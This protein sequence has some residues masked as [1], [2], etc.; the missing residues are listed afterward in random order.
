MTVCRWASRVACAVGAA[1]G[2]ALLITVASSFLPDAEPELDV[3]DRQLPVL[4][5]QTRQLQQPDQVF[6]PNLRKARHGDSWPSLRRLGKA[7]KVLRRWLSEAMAPESLDGGMLLFPAVKV[8]EEPAPNT[9]ANASVHMAPESLDG[10]MLLFPPVVLKEKAEEANQNGT[11]MPPWE[12]LGGGMVLFPPMHLDDNIA[13]GSESAGMVLFPPVPATGLAWN[14][15]TAAPTPSP[16]PVPTPAPTAVPTPAPPTPAPEDGNL[17]ILDFTTST[18]TI[19]STTTVTT[20]TTSTVTTLTTSTTSPVPKV[21]TELSGDATAGETSLTLLDVHGLSSGMPVT[22]ADVNNSETHNIVQVN[23]IVSSNGSRRLHAG[24]ITIDSPLQFSYDAGATITGLVQQ[25]LGG[26]W[27]SMDTNSDGTISSAEFTANSN[28]LPQTAS[29]GDIDTNGD[30]S[31]TY[32]EYMA[33]EHTTDTT[34]T[35]IIVA[36]ASSSEDDKDKN[37]NWWIP[38]VIIIVVLIVAWICFVCITKSILHL[39]EKRKADREEKVPFTDDQGL[40]KDEEVINIGGPPSHAAAHEVVPLGGDSK[41]EDAGDK[42]GTTS[43]QSEIF[44][45]GK[46]EDEAKAKGSEEAGA[47]EDME[48]KEEAAPREMEVVDLQARSSGD[49]LAIV[50]GS[51]EATAPIEKEQ[52]AESEKPP[53]LLP[54]AAPPAPGPFMQ[55]F[56][57]DYY[58]QHALRSISGPALEAVNRTP[59]QEYHREVAE[60][61]LQAAV[62]A[63]S[64]S[65]LTSAIAYAKSLAVPTDVVWYAE[66]C[67]RRRTAV[68]ELQDIVETLTGKRAS[69]KLWRALWAKKMIVLQDLLEQARKDADSVLQELQSQQ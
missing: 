13:T 61:R 34:T 59:Y 57:K 24:I 7:G 11:T 3:L 65:E 56:D 14:Q 49:G 5:A 53:L 60:N 69:A 26:T 48:T 12:D 36:A 27:D 63:D 10:G 42:E 41:R 33:W 30:N 22:I 17:S 9:S 25:G 28:H 50:G 55:F 32:G 1:I 2:A 39:L 20:T 45:A 21:V 38:L 16:T 47:P 68:A 43:M 29:F 6:S 51:G 4:K 67:R 52:E 8:Y 37:D 23:V 31:I 19:I 18:T 46:D 64:L 66:V 40:H 35:T 62:E 44:D 58:S 54:P 15:T